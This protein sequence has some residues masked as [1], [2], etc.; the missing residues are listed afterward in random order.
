[1]LVT[2]PAVPSAH[3]LQKSWESRL[4]VT[5]CVFEADIFI[6]VQVF[7]SHNSPMKGG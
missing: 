3:Y 1:M 7:N 6:N 4:L 2:L 5:G